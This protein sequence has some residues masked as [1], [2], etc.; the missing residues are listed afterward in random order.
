MSIIH[1]ANSLN[2][3]A[4]EPICDF[5]TK[6]TPVP[7]TFL[8]DFDITLIMQEAIERAYPDPK[9]YIQIHIKRIVP[10]FN[11]VTAVVA[12]QQG[13]ALNDKIEYKLRW[14]ITSVPTYIREC[15]QGIGP[16]L[17]KSLTGVLCLQ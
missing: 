12:F 7:Y 11:R 9:Y 4:H 6:K 5:H 17:L 2:I 15:W 13:S 1:Q 8:K 16:I 14:H 3:L 10:H